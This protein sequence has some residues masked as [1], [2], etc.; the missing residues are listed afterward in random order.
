MTNLT[1]TRKAPL[2]HNK[3]SSV[4]DDIPIRLAVTF[5]PSRARVLQGEWISTF[6]NK[7]HAN[8][9]GLGVL[10]LCKTR[11]SPNLLSS[12]GIL[13]RKIHAKIKES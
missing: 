5:A 4:H 13:S 2:G 3:R 9:I 1:G 12:L 6:C 7:H 10:S 11:P 8:T